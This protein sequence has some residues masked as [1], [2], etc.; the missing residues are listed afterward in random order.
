MIK[1]VLFD[2]DGT[3][4]DTERIYNWCWVEAAHETGCMEFTREDALSLRSLNHKDAEI[5]IAERFNGTVDYDAIHK[6]C[7]QKVMAYCDEHGV[8]LKP[9]VDEILSYLKEHNMKSAVVTA[10]ALERALPR[11][12]AVGLR[13]SFD[14]VISAHQVKQGKP[15][16]DS[17][18]FACE[19][20]GLKPEECIAVEDSP[21]G[22]LSAYGAGCPTIMVPDLTEPD[23]ALQ[24]ILFATCKTLA[25]IKDVIEEKC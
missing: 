19:K 18:I 14:E 4:T 16:P 23:E 10:T 8:P 17:Y 2:M 9:G 1:A 20:L 3:I 22:V 13:D 6:L 25:D 15:H 7:G 12:E 5:L 11:L 21:N 24:K